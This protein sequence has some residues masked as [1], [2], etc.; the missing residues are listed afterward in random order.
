MA[1]PSNAATSRYGTE[2]GA[3]VMTMKIRLLGNEFSYDT[4]KYLTR[5]YNE[6]DPSTSTIHT[7]FFSTLPKE[8]KEI[9]KKKVRMV[10]TDDMEDKAAPE[11]EMHVCDGSPKRKTTVIGGEEYSFV[12]LD[13]LGD[14]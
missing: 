10:K 6:R 13:I 14:G 1:L 12:D 8:A 2:S 9:K 5:V 11:Y 4:Y 7:F 3:Y